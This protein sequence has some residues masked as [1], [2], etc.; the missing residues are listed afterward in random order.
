MIAGIAGFVCHWLA[1]LTWAPNGRDISP[2]LGAHMAAAG[3][4][5]T[6]GTPRLAR[7]V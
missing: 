6:G 4:M 2:V 1:I 3:W 5:V 7:A